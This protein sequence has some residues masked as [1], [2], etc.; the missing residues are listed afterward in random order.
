MRNSSDNIVLE[1]NILLMNYTFRLEKYHI[2]GI[3]KSAWFIYAIVYVFDNTDH[4]LLMFFSNIR[5]VSPSCADVFEID[6]HGHFVESVQEF[7]SIFFIMVARVYR[8][9]KYVN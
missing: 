7:Y 2:Y 1:G 4:L 6:F 9:K 5:L 8:E 3:F